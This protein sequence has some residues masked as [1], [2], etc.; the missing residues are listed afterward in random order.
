MEKQLVDT[1]QSLELKLAETERQ[2][3]VDC[4]QGRFSSLSL[5]LFSG[6][7]IK[8][9]ELQ[10]AQAAKAAAKMQRLVGVLREQVQS[11][12]KLDQAPA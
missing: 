7:R 10:A 1:K 6:A 8:E 2:G 12:R 4:H 5:S 9:L 3:R 11:L